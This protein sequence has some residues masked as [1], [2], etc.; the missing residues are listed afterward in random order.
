MQEIGK[1]FA[2]LSVGF[3]LSIIIAVF[4]FQVEMFKDG[5]GMLSLGMPGLMYFA[6]GFF[7]SLILM[8]FP[9]PRNHKSY[10]LFY[11]GSAFIVAGLGTVDLMAGF[12][13]APASAEIANAQAMLLDVM[14]LAAVAVFWGTP[15]VV[16]AAYAIMAWY[17]TR[18]AAPEQRIDLKNYVELEQ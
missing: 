5:M 4:M 14:R 12:A 8:C 7:S 10:M 18:S 13:T 11:P 3:V 17:H 6:G 9:G 15:G 2:G 16:T 1:I